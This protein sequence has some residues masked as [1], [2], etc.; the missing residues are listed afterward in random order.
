MK[1]T[2]IILVLSLL[3]TACSQSDTTLSQRIVGTWTNQSLDDKKNALAVSSD[4]SFL[5]M[6]PQ[7]DH[8][9]NIMAGSWQISDAVYIMT[10]TNVTSTSTHHPSVGQTAHFRVLHLDEHTFA[11]YDEESHLTNS[12][13]R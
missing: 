11:Y 7:P 4:G 3:L 9:T 12:Y 5:L 6:A 1:N 8:T 10:F 2:P 13:S